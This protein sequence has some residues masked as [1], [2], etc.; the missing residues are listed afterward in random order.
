MMLTTGISMLGKISVGV[1]KIAIP[2]I[3]KI[4]MAMTTK[5]Y[6]RRNANLTIHILESSGFCYCT[7]RAR[8]VVVLASANRLRTCLLRASGAPSQAAMAKPRRLRFRCVN[9]VTGR[10]GSNS[11]GCQQR[12]EWLL[13]V[14]VRREILVSDEN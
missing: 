12:R 7:R 14:R 10:F 13:E 11:T 6:G 2:P 9:G 8:A 3:T 4:S 1:R 5:V